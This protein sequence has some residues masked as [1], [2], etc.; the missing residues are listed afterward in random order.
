GTDRVA[1]NGDVANKIG[2]YGV[3]VMAKAHNIPFYVAC[4]LST[5]DLSTPTGAD[6]PIEERHPDEVSH[7]FGKRTAPEGVAI[8]NPAFDIT[9]SELVTAIITEK[10]IVRAPY[11]ES[12]KNLFAKQ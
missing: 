2:T 1:A 8:Y 4:P 6:I 12:L 10:G 7:G 5:I 11:S 3:A 9:P